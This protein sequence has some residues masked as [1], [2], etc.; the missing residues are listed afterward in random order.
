MAFAFCEIANAALSVGDA[1]VAPELLG[2]R[3]GWTR[4]RRLGRK[5]RLE[6]PG[7]T[8][9]DSPVTLVAPP[10]GAQ[11]A[12]VALQH[13]PLPADIGT[14]PVRPFEVKAIALHKKRVGKAIGPVL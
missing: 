8:P 6:N 7:R 12:V 11:S 5:P 4:P 1:W 10:E 13:R 3:N 14:I 9:R 2:A